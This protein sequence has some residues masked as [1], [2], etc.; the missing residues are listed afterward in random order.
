MNQGLMMVSGFL[1]TILLGSAILSGMNWR[2]I[3]LPAGLWSC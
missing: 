2:W 3:N 1:G